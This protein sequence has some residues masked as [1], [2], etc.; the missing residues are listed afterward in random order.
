[1]SISRS[2]LDSI[3]TSFATVSVGT[4]DDALEDKLKA[5]SGAGFQAIELGFP[6]LVSFAA[7][8]H[9]KEIKEN[10]YDSLCSAG[11]EVKALCKKYNLDIMMLQPFSNFEGWPLGSKE[12]DDAFSRA[13]G[14]IRIMQ[15]VG[16]D[17]LQV[18]SR[19]PL[20]NSSILTTTR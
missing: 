10:D 2:S 3:P 5:I 7:K 12:R 16:T 18:R 11:T 19:F 17:M 4:P 14:W 8:H 13:K 20:Q 9:K 1:M 6:N 15:A